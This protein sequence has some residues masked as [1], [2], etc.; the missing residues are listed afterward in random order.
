MIFSLG[1]CLRPACAQL[2]LKTLPGA[3]APPPKKPHAGNNINNNSYNS[4]Y[5]NNDNKTAN[6][7][8]KVCWKHKFRLSP[9]YFC[10]HFLAAKANNDGAEWSLRLSWPWLA[11][12]CA[13]AIFACA[14]AC[15]CALLGTPCACAFSVDFALSVLAPVLAPCLGHLVPVVSLYDG[16]IHKTT[17]LLDQQFK[18][19]YR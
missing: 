18:S 3:Q 5:N 11:Q 10:M 4:N 16:C 7:A 8:S 6:G 13:R 9:V 1:K 19:L 17:M 12:P 2:A 14:C 15:A